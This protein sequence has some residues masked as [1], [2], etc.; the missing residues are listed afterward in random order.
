MKYLSQK[1]V[2][3][4]DA[5]VPQTHRPEMP[6]RGFIEFSKNRKINGNR[7]IVIVALRNL[8]RTTCYALRFKSTGSR[9]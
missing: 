4:S 6:E 9:A 3:S 7:S 8:Q 2:A 5:S 1:G